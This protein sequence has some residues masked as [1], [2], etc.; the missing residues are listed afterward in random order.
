MDQRGK[1]QMMPSVGKE[2]VLSMAP[3]G[4]QISSM[5]EQK[6]GALCVKHLTVCDL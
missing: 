1:R 4:M 3:A 2:K 5:L 6:N